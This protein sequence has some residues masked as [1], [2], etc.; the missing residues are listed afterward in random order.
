M[1][2]AFRKRQQPA[3]VFPTLPSAA[4]ALFAGTF[5]RLPPRAQKP[6]F[7]STRHDPAR[8]SPEAGRKPAWK[9]FVPRM[10]PPPGRKRLNAAFRENGSL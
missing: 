10:P 6:D 1:P 5:P 2:A 3:D 7:R 8:P 4:T 9:E